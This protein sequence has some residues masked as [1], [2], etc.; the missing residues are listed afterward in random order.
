MLG[1]DLGARFVRGALCDLDGD[2]PRAP[3]RRAGRRG[4]EGASRRSRAARVPARHGRPR[5]GAGGQRRRRRPGRRRA[6]TGSCRWPRTSPAS[7][8]PTSP[9]SSRR[10]LD[11]PVT[12]ENDINLAALGEQWQESREAST[13]SSSSRSE[14]AWAQGSCSRGE[15]HRGHHGAAGELDFALV[16]LGET[17]DPSAPQVAELARGL[18]SSAPCTARGLRRRPQRRPGRM[19]G[20]RRDRP[21][22]RAPRRACRRG[23]ATS[24]SSF[25]AAASARTATSCSIRS[26]GCWPSGCPSRRAS[27]SPRWV[28]PPCSRERSRSGAKRRSRTSSPGERRPERRDPR[29]SVGSTHLARELRGHVARPPIMRSRAGPPP[30][31]LRRR[32][33]RSGVS[34]SRGAGCPFSIRSR[35]ISADASARVSGNPSPA[36]SHSAPAS[37]YTCRTVG[38][39]SHMTPLSRKRCDVSVPT[40]C[41]LRVSRG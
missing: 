36:C 34:E 28:R 13:T 16:G 29:L 35:S 17:V 30:P 22:H 32:R 39:P 27:R 15:L 1:L 25:S 24:S 41:R 2:Y 31:R 20:R 23:G 10:A 19:R 6:G 33:R 7:R 12:L 5:P 40:L 18:P 21:T 37:A 11:F 4:A 26:P 8:A 9:R 3:G 38:G 14:P